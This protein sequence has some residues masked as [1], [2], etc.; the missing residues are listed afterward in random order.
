M[1]SAIKGVNKILHKIHHNAKWN[2][3][4]IVTKYFFVWKLIY[5]LKILS[6]WMNDFNEILSISI[7]IECW[8]FF[9]LRRMQL[10][11][12]FLNVLWEFS[13]AKVQEL[14]KSLTKYKSD[15]WAFTVQQHASVVTIK[16]SV[17]V[18]IK[19]IWNVFV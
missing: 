6:I 12:T 9:R 14:S 15:E 1:T 19:T 16:I 8:D 11:K 2:V 18:P 7:T 10:R 3:T 17:P 4:V 5:W 13:R